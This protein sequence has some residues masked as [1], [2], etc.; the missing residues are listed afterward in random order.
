MFRDWTVVLS[1][2]GGVARAHLFENMPAGT[3]DMAGNEFGR[4][5][6]VSGLDDAR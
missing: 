1:G 4:L 5:V 3:L 6:G 2:P